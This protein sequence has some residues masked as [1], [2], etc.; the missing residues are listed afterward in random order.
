MRHGPLSQEQ[1]GFV[2]EFAASR[3]E[4]RKSRP[5]EEKAEFQ[6]EL[7]AQ[8]ITASW[9]FPL[10]VLDDANPWSSVKQ[11]WQQRQ[12]AAAIFVLS[13]PKE[14]FA[15]VVGTRA[16]V[17]AFR[18]WFLRYQVPG[19]HK[20]RELKEDSPIVVHPDDADNPFEYV[21]P[22]QGGWCRWEGCQEIFRRTHD[23][24]RRHEQDCEHRRPNQ[25]PLPE[26]RFKTRTMD[27]KG[28]VPSAAALQLGE[29][30]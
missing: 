21:P 2:R 11:Q 24:R 27:G 19:E 10:Y 23:A 29:E 1:R 8:T 12:G 16:G 17:E 7:L 6:K 15:K 30:A 14:G 18:E 5:S 28:P 3:R 9:T 22:A 20:S 26:L 4:P 25:V 13:T